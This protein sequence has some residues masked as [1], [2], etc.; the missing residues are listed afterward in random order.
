MK[1]NITQTVLENIKRLLKHLS[2]SDSEREELYSL[3]SDS[4][5]TLP[6]YVKLNRS[7]RVLLFKAFRVLSNGLLRSIFQRVQKEE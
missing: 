6:F 1:D 2:I 4:D 7:D 5:M 3:L